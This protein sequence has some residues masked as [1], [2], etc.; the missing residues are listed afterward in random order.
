MTATRLSRL[1]RQQADTG[2]TPTKLAHLA[3]IAN[4]GPISLGELAHA[5][6]VSAPTVTKVVRDLE[7]RGLVV[8]EPDATDKRV[9]LVRST[10]D[11]DAILDQS[12]SRK[13]LWLS[14]QMAGLSAPE[15]AQLSGAIDLLARITE[16]ED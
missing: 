13:D 4:D 9:S 16:R 5:E 7:N 11:G 6:R 8:R 15:L 1:L 2:L 3:T 14:E 10:P 12:R